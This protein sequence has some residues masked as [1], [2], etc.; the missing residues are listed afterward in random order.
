MML[1][2]CPT[3]LGG[4]NLTS[5]E[6]QGDTGRTE[7]AVFSARWLSREEGQGVE[8]RS[9]R[10]LMGF[11]RAREATVLLRPTDPCAGASGVS[12]AEIGLPRGRRRH[13]PGYETAND[14]H[15]VLS[16][17]RIEMDTTNERF[18]IEHPRRG[19]PNCLQAA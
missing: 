19:N 6:G 17:V 10:N 9:N 3:G 4:R 16:S 1:K 2:D 12:V 14:A 18:A 15:S 13:H 8:R 11:A 5:L 7:F